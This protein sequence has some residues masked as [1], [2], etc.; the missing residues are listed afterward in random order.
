MTTL[1][2]NQTNAMTAL[3]KSCL[4]NMGGETLSHLQDDPFT[5]VD[6]SDLVSAGWNQKQAE[7]TFGSLVAE[8]LI[9]ENDPGEYFLTSDWVQ[10]SKFHA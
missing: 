8:G 5:W 3:I 6:T 4:S 10:L 1:T 7:G 9:F 2:Q